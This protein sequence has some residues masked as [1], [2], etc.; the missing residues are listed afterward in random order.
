LNFTKKR[1][2]KNYKKL[3]KKARSK[4]MDPIVNIIQNVEYYNHVAN[5]PP[6]L[7]SQ[8]ALIFGHYYS[9]FA[10]P[11]IEAME[12][13]NQYILEIVNDA[14]RNAIM[15]SELNRVLKRFKDQLNFSNQLNRLLS[16][17]WLLDILMNMVNILRKVGRAMHCEDFSYGKDIPLL[18]P[19]YNE[20]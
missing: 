11:C 5:H 2:S 1:N 13:M 16:V 12:E 8:R 15:S 6:P 14:P 19:I 7:V 10:Q 20:L 17:D 18:F 4:T 3:Q 9:K